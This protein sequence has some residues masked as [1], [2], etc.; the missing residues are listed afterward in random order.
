MLSDNFKD[1]IEKIIS[2]NY[3]DTKEWH[4]DVKEWK[5]ERY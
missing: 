3:S 2:E 1:G 5:E 4:P